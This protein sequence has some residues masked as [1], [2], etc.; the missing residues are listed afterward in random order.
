MVLEARRELEVLCARLAAERIT[1]LELENLRQSAL[2]LA[3]SSDSLSAA[4]ENL[5]FHFGVLRAAHNPVLYSLVGAVRSLL[6]DSTVALYYRAENIRDAGKAHL[7]IVEALE[8]RNAA[9]AASRM[10]KHLLAFERYLIDTGQVVDLLKEPSEGVDSDVLEWLQEL[11]RVN[12]S[13]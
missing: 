8:Q 4:K 12:G 7:R 13:K 3:E 9:L 11:D 10:E 1:D 5:I 2:R 6:Y